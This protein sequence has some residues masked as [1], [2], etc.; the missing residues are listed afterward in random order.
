MI[1][2]EPPKIAAFN[3]DGIL[4][5]GSFSQISCVVT[6]G[7]EPL[8]I[9]WSFHGHNLTSDLGVRIADLGSRMSILVIQSV[10]HKHMGTYTCKASNKAGAVS[11]S[12]TLKVNGNLSVNRTR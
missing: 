5:E 8:K 11:H 1:F 4:N 6:E 3:F 7:D 9:S 2:S 10:S 12:A